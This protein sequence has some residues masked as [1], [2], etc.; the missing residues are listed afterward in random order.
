M[1]HSLTNYKAELS[2]RPEALRTDPGAERA[3]GAHKPHQPAGQTNEAPVL[4]GH[5]SWPR[6]SP[7]QQREGL[8]LSKKGVPSTECV[9]LGDPRTG[10]AELQTVRRWGDFSGAGFPGGALSG[11][12]EMSSVCGEGGAGVSIREMS[13]SWA[14]KVHVYPHFTAISHTHKQCYTRV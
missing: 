3:L 13:L 5:T 10:T 8:A 4:R 9:P 1:A 6:R 11:V 14:V 7:S 12:L 2:T